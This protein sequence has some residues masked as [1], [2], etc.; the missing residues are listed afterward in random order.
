MRNIIDSFTNLPILLRIGVIGA[1]VILVGVVAL[2]LFGGS[3][4]VD[5][6]GDPAV[7]ED[8]AGDTASG[9][10]TESEVVD[11][12][13]SSTAPEGAASE[14]QTAV[15]D[16]DAAMNEDETDPNAEAESDFIVQEDEAADPND[17]GGVTAG[18][19]DAD[20]TDDAT[21]LPSNPTMQDV[22]DNLD[23]DTMDLPGTVT[24][25]E[26]SEDPASAGETPVSDDSNASEIK[27]SLNDTQKELWDEKSWVPVDLGS[28]AAPNHIEVMPVDAAEA[29]LSVDPS[30]GMAVLNLVGID[31]PADQTEAASMR[32][33]EFLGDADVVVVEHDP[34]V[35]DPNTVYIHGDFV[36]IQEVLLEEGLATVSADDTTYAESFKLY[37]QD[38]KDNNLG[39]WAKK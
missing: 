25:P 31:I 38:A 29:R 36:N 6:A 10:E 21:G 37:E 26:D 1:V 13:N 14:A 24:E 7:S 8:V 3:D 15:E 12:F 5:Q 33:S 22:E 16:T 2:N 4:D 11:D 19:T 17:V 9:V 34:S 18:S 27:A 32:I 23:N 30:T 20:T 28:V 35:S 39:V